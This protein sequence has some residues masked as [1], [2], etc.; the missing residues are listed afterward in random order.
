VR[1]FELIKEVVND[2]YTKTSRLHTAEKPVIRL[3]S[4]LAEGS[5]RF[6]ANIALQAGFSLQC[7]LPLSLE[8]YKKDFETE[9]SKNEFTK[10]LDKADSIFEIEAGSSNRNRAYQNGGQVLLNH[11]DILLAIWD[12]KDSGKVGGTSDIV[13]LAQQQDIPVVWISSI[14]PHKISIIYGD[15]RKYE[16]ASFEKNITDIITRILLPSRSPLLVLRHT[17]LKIRL[18]GAKPGCISILRLCF[19]IQKRKRH[20]HILKPILMI[21]IKTTITSIFTVR[22]SWQNDTVIYTAH[23]E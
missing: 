1:F 3:L 6:A 14:A 21:F 9:E 4:M 2:C 18:K 11:S 13:S 16:E 15:A 17:L 20:R 22:M 10:L 5:D 19:H 23:A 7:P 8:E 12:H